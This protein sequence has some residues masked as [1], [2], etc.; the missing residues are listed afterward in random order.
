MRKPI[1]VPMPRFYD[2]S[3]D[4]MRDCCR[5]YV[6]FYIHT[7]SILLW[8][9]I[10]AVLSYFVSTRVFSSTKQVSYIF[11]YDTFNEFAS[12]VYPGFKH[13]YKINYSEKSS[14]LTF[15]RRYFQG[16]HEHV[17]RPK[18]DGGSENNKQD[19]CRSYF[20]F[21]IHTER[22]FSLLLLTLKT[23]HPRMLQSQNKIAIRDVIRAFIMS[24]P[25]IPWMFWIFFLFSFVC[26]LFSDSS[27][28][29]CRMLL[30]FV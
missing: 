22:A 1:H 28:S 8:V 30:L 17:V 24:W 29:V 23:A 5:S 3:G 20:S 16:G 25:W 4:K 15:F 14:Q 21:Y 9:I 27:M 10:V 7:E 6:S 12:N 26:L 13:K 19:S 11:I 2:G 18:I